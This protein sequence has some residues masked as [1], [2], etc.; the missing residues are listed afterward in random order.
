MRVCRADSTKIVGNS[1]SFAELSRPSFFISE[2]IVPLARAFNPSGQLGPS[3]PVLGGQDE[4]YLAA[5]L[6]KL[7][8][9]LASARHAHAEL[10]KNYEFRVSVF[11]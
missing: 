2:P 5:V 7:T 6:S 9:D 3:S 8:E 11:V 1:P 10:Q 4:A